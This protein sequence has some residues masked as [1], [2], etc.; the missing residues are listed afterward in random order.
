M[1][2]KHLRRGST[3]FTFRKTQI[4]IGR[5]AGCRPLAGMSRNAPTEKATGIE[6]HG[7][8]SKRSACPANP[9]Q[10][11][12]RGR[13]RSMGAGCVSWHKSLSFVQTG[14]ASWSVMRGVKCCVHITEAYL[15]TERHEALIYVRPRSREGVQ[16]KLDTGLLRV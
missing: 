10:D 5:A 4:K 9:P 12:L 8:L 13:G 7:A 6:P 14:T 2:A 3:R 11:S 16:R 1:A 15:G